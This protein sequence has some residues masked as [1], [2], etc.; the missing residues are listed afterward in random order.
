MSS[1]LLS[2]WFIA[3]KRGASYASAVRLGS[4]G[5]KLPLFQWQLYILIIVYIHNIHH[6]DHFPDD[7][8]YRV[9]TETKQ[10]A[11]VW[12]SADLI[13]STQGENHTN[14]DISLFG[15]CTIHHNGDG[16][17]KHCSHCQLL[18]ANVVLGVCDFLYLCDG[19]HTENQ[20]SD[21]HA[22]AGSPPNLL[23]SKWSR[24]NTGNMTSGAS[25]K[26]PLVI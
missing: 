13:W 26:Y 5:W 21:L 6:I 7:V 1:S 3:P 23:T 22:G 20:R 12:N 4:N 9:L 19:P 15:L 2:S 24:C 10:Q 14:F 18:H 17:P 16:C 8:E 11:K 25:F